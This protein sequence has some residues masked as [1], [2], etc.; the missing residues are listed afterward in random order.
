M[1]G[2]IH[3]AQMSS[4]SMM[5]VALALASPLSRG[6][7]RSAHQ[8]TL[9]ICKAAPTLQSAGHGEGGRLA[10]QALEGTE[11]RWVGVT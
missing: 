9:G 3:V 5:I 10:S 1:R 7:Q 11:A 2:C 6:A 4:A 8:V